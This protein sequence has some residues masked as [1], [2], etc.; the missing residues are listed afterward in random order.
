MLS[1]TLYSENDLLTQVVSCVL[2]QIMKEGDSW[3]ETGRTGGQKCSRD[4]RSVMDTVERREEDSC[5]CL[6]NI[7]LS[8]QISYKCCR[9]LFF[10]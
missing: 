1:R 10:S 4:S 9:L 3:A 2:G 7:V 8:P 5:C 6:D